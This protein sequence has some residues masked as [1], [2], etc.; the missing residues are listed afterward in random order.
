[1]FERGAIGEWVRKRHF[2]CLH[3][4]EDGAEEFDK[5]RV[6]RVVGPEAEDATWV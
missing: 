6:G 2:V 3:V 1:M 5:R 4:L